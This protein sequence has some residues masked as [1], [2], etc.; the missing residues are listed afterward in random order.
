M[1]CI[2][3]VAITA[4]YNWEPYLA[5]MP[6]TA[7]QGDLAVDDTSVGLGPSQGVFSHCSLRKASA[8]NPVI[9]GLGGSAGIAALLPE[10]VFH[11]ATMSISPILDISPSSDNLGLSV[12]PP[13]AHTFMWIWSDAVFIL[14]VDA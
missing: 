9:T 14:S 6:V 5:L 13:P 3:F 2:D 1:P 10:P 8:A 11:P 7:M 4:S 12:W